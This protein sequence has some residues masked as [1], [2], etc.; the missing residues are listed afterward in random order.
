MGQVV[1]GLFTVGIGVIIV[2]AIF[3]LNKQNTP[4][5][6]AAANVADNTLS[7]IFK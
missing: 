7:A 4:L 1:G 5:V 6:P 3:Q 2:A